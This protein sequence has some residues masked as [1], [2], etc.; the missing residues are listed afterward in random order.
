M[1]SHLDIRAIVL[2][3]L[4][5]L[6]LDFIIGSVVISVFAGE[7]VAN[8]TDEQTRKAIIVALAANGAY[9]RTVLILGTATTVVGGFMIARIA[10]S[11]PYFNALAFGVVGV[12]LNVVP[13]SQVPIWLQVVGVALT[14]PAALLGA[15]LA[16]RPLSK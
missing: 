10:R 12:L 11:L 8:A 9:L 13:A 6:G 7:Q 5:I 2:T 14:I 1:M 16:R 3:T 15:Y 4:A